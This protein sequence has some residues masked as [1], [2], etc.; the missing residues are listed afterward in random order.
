[1]QKPEW[2]E[3]R[4][5]EVNEH[6]VK[7]HTH[8][9]RLFRTRVPLKM[10]DKQNYHLLLDRRQESTNTLLKIDTFNNKNRNHK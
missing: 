7:Q 8:D 4:I 9:E 3:S 2:F 5:S 10:F 6:N 1:M